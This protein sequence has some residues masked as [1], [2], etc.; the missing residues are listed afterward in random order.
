MKLF[1]FL[2]LLAVVNICSGLSCQRCRRRKCVPESVVKQSCEGGV[3]TDP[4]G[5]CLVCAKQFNESCGG[6]WDVLGKCDIG[7]FCQ[8]D[9]PSSYPV[10]PPF[11][12][13]GTCA[14]LG[15]LNHVG[16]GY[17]YGHVLP[18]HSDGCLLINGGDNKWIDVGH[19]ITRKRTCKTW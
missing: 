4:C 14:K 18:I 6:T 12:P 8:R 3:V 5:C 17:R 19:T 15:K 2:L 16:W 7:L 11:F 9:T 1:V 13:P 10:I